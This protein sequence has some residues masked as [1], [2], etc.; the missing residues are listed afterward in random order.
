MVGTVILPGLAFL[1]LLSVPFVD[2]G[3][4]RRLRHRTLA[5]GVTFLAALGWTG[6]TATAIL[7]NPKTDSSGHQEARRY[8]NGNSY[9]RR[10]LPVS[11][12]IAMRSV[13]LA[14]TSGKGL[15]KLVPI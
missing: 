9:R 15:Q 1:A 6:L 11:H 7:T 3:E 12:T 14:I 10:S 2:R 4:L 13:P 8:R 5:I